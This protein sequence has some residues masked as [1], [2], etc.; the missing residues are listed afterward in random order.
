MASREIGFVE[1]ARL[2]RSSWR[3]IVGLGLA[4]GLLTLLALQLLVPTQYAATARLVLHPP[5]QGSEAGELSMRYYRSLLESDSILQQTHDRLIEQGVLEPDETLVLGTDLYTRALTADSASQ[6][7]VLGVVATRRDPELAAGIA[8]AWVG[9]FL[10]N[11]GSL[12]RGTAPASEDA[13]REELEPTRQKLE[14]AEQERARLLD[15]LQEREETASTTWDQ[16]IFAARKR[17]ETAVAAHLAETRQLLEEC[18]ARHLAAADTAP[19]AAVRSRLLELASVRAQQAQTPRIL[20]LEKAAS[21]E[22]LAELIAEGSD[23]DRFD[24]TLVS[25]ELNP[26]YD[27]LAVAALELEAAL[28]RQA[29]AHG[30]EVS[31]TLAELE[32]IQIERAAALATLRSR[33]TLEQR[34]LRRRRSRALEDLSRERLMILT[35]MQRAISKLEDL[36]RQLSARIN[37]SVIATLIED[38]ELVSLAA[39]ALPPQD[40]LPRELPLKTTVAVFLGALLG[41]MIAL[42]RSAA[43]L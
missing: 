40:G 33:S 39:P 32:A 21:D 22:T 6:R 38:V 26:L 34:T 25:E 18:V 16:R 31:A 4:S 1:L 15:E 41:L 13:L 5:I 36:D 29:E 3:L 8:N 11:S 10:E 7:S 19:P 2:T 35:D 42:F 14:E 12:L 27:Q 23:A 37:Q 9:V 24:S 17:A 30:F 43:R 28:T 20:T